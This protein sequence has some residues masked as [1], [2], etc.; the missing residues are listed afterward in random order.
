M[1][2]NGIS[3]TGENDF[4]Q[5]EPRE[6]RICVPIKEDSLAASLLFQKALVFTH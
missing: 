2:Q 6:T 5:H 3:T 1:A 4:W